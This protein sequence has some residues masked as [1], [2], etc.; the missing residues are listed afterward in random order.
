MRHRFPPSVPV[1][2]VLHRRPGERIRIK[3]PDGT[4]IWVSVV[5]TTP[6]RA[7]IG[8]HTP[9]SVRVDRE[10]VTEREDY[11]GE[12]RRGDDRPPPAA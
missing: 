7:V 8:I 4:L 6:N 3:L 10:E 2:L 1:G 12:E 5:S 9:A 11:R